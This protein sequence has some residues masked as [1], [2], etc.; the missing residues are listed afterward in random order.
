LFSI[1]RLL[2]AL[3]E[4]LARRGEALAQLSLALKLDRRRG[5]LEPEALRPAVPTLDGV[6]LMDLVRLRLET[7][8]LA[9]GVIEV[10]VDAQGTPANAEQLRVFAEQPRR[11]PAAAQRAIARLRAEFGAD[12]VVRAVLADGHLPEACFS[13]QALEELPLPAARPAGELPLPAARPAG[14]LPLPA[15]SPAGELLREAARL[16]PAPAEGVEAML[17]RRPLIR[18]I[19]RRP[20]LLAAPGRELRNDGWLIRGSEHGPVTHSAGPYLVTGGWWLREVQREYQFILTRRGELLWVY[21]DK[22]RRRWFL[23]GEVQ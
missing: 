23:Q 22:R 2:D 14:E 11:D 4:E 16:D 15:A 21:H 20:E 13:W 1:K 9:D 3:L 5:S 6:Q 12:S 17:A 8:S 19:F 18:R 7:L 10:T